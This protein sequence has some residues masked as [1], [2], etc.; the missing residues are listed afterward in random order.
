MYNKTFLMPHRCQKT[1]WVIIAIAFV[2]AVCFFCSII[3][4][5]QAQHTVSA[6]LTSL[7][8]L[9]ATGL[10]LVCFS[11]EKHEDE[12]IGYLRTQILTWIIVYVF[13]VVVAREVL[14]FLLTWF[15]SVSVH[16]T[17]MTI[18]SFLP[19]NP[20]ILGIIYLIIFKTVIWLTKR[21]CD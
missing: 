9:S 12:Y 1:G 2:I 17:A 15:A 6:L 11:K 18:V 4:N 13:A 16:G 21:K 14:G 5:Y 10:L 3:L 8:L 7:V 19:T 20:I